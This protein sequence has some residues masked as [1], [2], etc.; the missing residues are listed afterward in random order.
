MRFGWLT[1]VAAAACVGLT[2]CENV[3]NVPV[4]TA[5][6]AVSAADQANA[7]ALLAR[8]LRD[9]ASAQFRDW[10]GYALSNGDRV[11]CVQINGTNGYGG[12]AGFEPRYVRLRG[13]TALT[14]LSGQLAAGGCALAARGQYSVAPEGGLY[15]L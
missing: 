8:E 10:Q 12:Y 4:N 9:P 7:S 6:R 14:T 1:G 13:E 2:A 3:N 11:V 5:P 15:T